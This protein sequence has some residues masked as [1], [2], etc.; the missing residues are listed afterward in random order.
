MRGKT[1]EE[2]AQSYKDCWECVV[3]NKPD[4]LEQKLKGLK[5]DATRFL[6][7]NKTTISCLKKTV[8]VHFRCSDV[9]FIKHINYHLQP[10]S[11]WKYVADKIVKL[12]GTEVQFLLCPFAINNVQIPSATRCPV[13]LE[14]IVSFLKEFLPSN[15][16][17]NEVPNCWSS[18]TT[19]LAM[20]HADILVSGIESSFVFI[21]GVFKRE[22]FITPRF[23][24]E[25]YRSRFAFHRL[26]AKTIFWSMYDGPPI[27]HKFV[28][29][30]DSDKYFN[31]STFNES[32]LPV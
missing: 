27:F 5:V 20:R 6:E 10:K 12:G 30:Y 9:P 11:Y 26:V 16:K 29:S 32:I 25:L 18:A 7:N 21:A 15:V 1:Q 19:L 2:V 8:L 23:D 28:K 3:K 14:T 24:I 31:Y 13:F 4:W 17:I 22:R